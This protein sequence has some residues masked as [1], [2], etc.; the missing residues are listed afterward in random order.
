MQQAYA[1]ANEMVMLAT[2]EANEILDQATADAN[3]IRSAAIAYTDEMLHSME[4]MLSHAL[5]TSRAKYDNLI[6]SLENCYQIVSDNR[7]ELCPPEDAQE[8][9]A[10][11]DEEPQPTEEDVVNALKGHM[12]QV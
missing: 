11:S 10:A 6:Q 7:K 2:N 3:E 9:K 8:E 12:T 5:D 1:K 4:N